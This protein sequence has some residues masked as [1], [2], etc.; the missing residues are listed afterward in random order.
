[1][2]GMTGGCNTGGVK[3]ST[4]ECC[5]VHMQLVAKRLIQT[6]E[7]CQLYAASTAKSRALESHVCPP[8]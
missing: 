6:G 8:N 5:R 4:H 2:L 7:H 1:M 3:S